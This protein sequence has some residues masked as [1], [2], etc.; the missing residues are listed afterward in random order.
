MIHSCVHAS[1]R[2]L[3]ASC[4]LLAVQA[5]L[6][7]Y[8]N[9][10]ERWPRSGDVYR[11]GVANKDYPFQ[12]Q[13]LC[14]ANGAGDGKFGSFPFPLKKRPGHPDGDWTF[15]LSMD[16]RP[17]CKAAIYNKGKNIASKVWNIYIPLEKRLLVGGTELRSG[18]SEEDLLQAIIFNLKLA[19]DERM[20][21]EAKVK[22]E[23]EAQKEAAATGARPA[24]TPEPA[25][26]VEE[27]EEEEQPEK[28]E[29]F[30]GVTDSEAEREEAAAA[31]SPTRSA[32]KRAAQ[33]AE[34]R[35][36]KAAQKEAQSEMEAQREEVLD[37]DFNVFTRTMEADRDVFGGHHQGP[38]GQGHGQGQGQGQ[39]SIRVRVRVLRSGSFASLAWCHH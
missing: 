13:A 21:A 24:A 8:I 16:K 12:L 27:E 35:R 38:Q 1:Y 6:R 23:T 33:A 4:L 26:A 3:C 15:A 20:E 10:V 29:D 30:G 28:D 17:K 31:A 14:G 36:Q 39:A 2:S 11:I 34:V 19:F 25:A 7:A 32:K 22:K 18:W 37:V 9:S 5:A